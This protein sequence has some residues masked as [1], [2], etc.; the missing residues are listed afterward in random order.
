MQILEN[1]AQIG[2]SPGGAVSLPAGRHDIEL[3]NE[4]IGYRETHTVH[5]AAGKVVPIV[6]TLPMGS[7]SVNALPWAEV[8]LD[9]Q[10]V[11]ETPIGNLEVAVGPHEIVFRHPQLGERR[12]SVV[13]PMTGPLR[14][15]VDLKKQP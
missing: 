6:V 8:W 15:S 1:G 2:T 3:V 11:G 7:I 10:K 12:E 5:V 4:S 13:V 9:G 14:V